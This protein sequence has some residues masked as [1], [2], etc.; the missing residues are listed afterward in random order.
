MCNLTPANRNNSVQN[1]LVKIVSRSLT[2]EHGRP[3]SFTISSK[4]ALATE[5]AEYGC[6]SAMKWLYFENRSTTVSTTDLP[7]TFGNLS[8]KS[9]EISAHTIEGIGKGCS[10]PAR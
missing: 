8:I 9:I 6:P 2:I 4:K 1:K 7:P 3:W 10:R 5:A